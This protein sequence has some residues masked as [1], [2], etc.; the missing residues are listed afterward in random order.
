MA[1]RRHRQ[2]GVRGAL[3]SSLEILKVLFFL[4]KMLS[5]TSVD[6][7]FMHNFEK[8]SSAFGTSHPDPYRGA[9]PGPCW[10]TSVLKTPHI[11]HP[12]KISCGR[13]YGYLTTWSQK[14]KCRS[15]FLDRRLIRSDIAV[16]R[17][18]VSARYYSPLSM[19]F[20]EWFYYNCCGIFH[21]MT[22]LLVYAS[23]IGHLGSDR[24][25][26]VKFPS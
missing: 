22:W 24:S 18:Q 7:V 17:W 16:F 11:A 20:A 12:W 13:P 4:L 10:G 6:E 23:L 9:A 26:I 5:K 1:A 19:H 15:S 8:M 2:G 21:F 25:F 3:A 14:R